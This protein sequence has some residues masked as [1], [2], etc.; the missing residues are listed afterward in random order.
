[1][2]AALCSPHF[3][4]WNES[5]EN[6]R[7]ADLQIEAQSRLSGNALASRLSAFLW[8]SMPDR[9]LRTAF[10][11]LDEGT[12]AGSRSEIRTHVRT[13]VERM[14]SDP[15]SQAFVYDF[16]D[17]WL[18][19]RDL[20][21]TPPDR[22]SFRAYYHYDLQSAMLQETRSF[23]A[24]LLHDN[25]A[26][27]NFIDC[28]F[29][30]LNKRLAELY[31]EEDLSDEQIANPNLFAKVQLSD[32][33]RGGLLGQASV[34]TVSAN[35]I[36]TSPVVRGV[37]VLE[38]LL[39]TPPPPPPPDVKPLDPDIRG[40]K[41]IRDQLQKHRS[42]ESCNSC[43]RR[44]DPIGFAL[45]NFDAIGR[46]RTHYDQKK[47]L[48]VETSGILPNGKTFA[49]VVEL[50]QILKTQPEVFARALA[51]KLMSYALGRHLT[52]S[53]R[54]YLD[55]IVQRHQEIG[56]GFRD[57]VHLIAASDLFLRP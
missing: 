18:T 13:Q 15:R 3:V 44:I 49:D 34:L 7:G 38:N 45:E 27:D 12:R 42:V 2:K 11:K 50:K 31:G 43:H 1:M 5:T 21:T 32:Q 39:G 6:I 14:L 26:I 41:T 40:A 23:A 57:L 17:S 54:P 46:V 30:F 9:E 36:D 4:Y 29:S 55:Q 25:L 35:G 37:W 28:E 56:G 16:L 20:G 24:H 22:S 51:H 10:E 19:L 48:E 8:S 53:D 52:L 33:R 47:Q